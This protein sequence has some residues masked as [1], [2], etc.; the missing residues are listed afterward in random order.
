MNNQRRKSIKEVIAKINTIKDLVQ[1]IYDE[2][3]EAYENMPENLRE[4]ERAMDSEEA[5]ENL[6]AVIEV[7]D[8][9]IDYLGEI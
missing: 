9:A 1:N 2:E 3:Q 6:E 7:L 5:Q 8:E 4:S